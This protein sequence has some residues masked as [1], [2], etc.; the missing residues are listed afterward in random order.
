VPIPNSVP[1]KWV[2]RGL[3]DASDG[4]NS[5]PGAQ[6]QLINLIPDPS[7]AGIYVPRP[8]AQIET[9]FTGVNAPTGPGDV[10]AMLTVGDLE[11]GMIASTRFA[12]KDEPYCYDL[13]NG[14][15]LPVAGVTNANT[16]TTQPSSGDWVPPIMAQVS[17]RVIV[18][19]PGFPGGAIKF[20][21]FDVS[22][23]SE[24][25]LGNTHTSTLIDGNPSVLGVQVGMSITGA[26]IPAN[27][28][29][30]ATTEFVLTTTALLNLNTLTHFGS[31]LGIA[32][33]Q[34]VA[35]LD[36]PFGTTVSSITTAAGVWTGST[37]SNTTVDNLVYASG[38][39]DFPI[40]GDPIS[41][42][43]IPANTEV[44]A[45]VAISFQVLASLNG[46]T[47]IQV[48]SIDGIV[49]NQNV[50]G[51]GIPAATTV[52]SATLFTLNTT[53]DITSGSAVIINL[54]STA[55]LLAGQKVIGFGIP[56]ISTGIFAQ[57]TIIVSVDSPTQVTISTP[58]DHTI[59]ANAITFSGGSV[60]LNNAAT[61]TVNFNLL[62]FS[63]LGV[64]LSQPAGATANGVSITVNTLTANL[65]AVSLNAAPINVPVTFT[66]ATITLSQAATGSVANTSLTIA[67]GTRAAPLWGAGDCDRNP[68]LSTP[69]GVM[70]MNGRAYFADGL[71][72][73]P[74]SDSGLP[75]RRSNQPDVQALTTNDGTAVTIVAPLEL[76]AP[77]TGGI[78]QAAIAFSGDG[79]MRQITGD[80][81]TADLKMNLLPIATG[82][83]APLSVIPCSLGT[84]F[85]SPQGLRF[86]RPD[87]SVTDPVGVDGQGVTHPF[88]YAVFPSRI[89]AEANVAVLRITVQHGSEPGQPFQEFWFD[90]SR[91]TWSGPHSFPARLIQ[92]W[93][94]S[95][96]MA[97][98]GVTASLWKSD[99][100]GP[101]YG[102]GTAADFIEN[103]VQL[104]WTQETV[105]LPDNEHMAM[106]SMVEANLM[107]S[108]APGDIIQVVA[109]DEQGS[110]L[111]A[112]NVVP[113]V[114]N[115]I[116]R[117]RSLHWH[118]PIIFKQMSMQARG[119]SNSRVRIGNLYMR[120]EILGYNND[121]DAVAT[122]YLRVVPLTGDTL[123]AV[124]GLLA[125]RIDPLG[126]LAT[127]A[128]VM[129]P[130]PSNGDSFC[131]S[132][133]QRLAVVT[134][135][136]PAST[137][138]AGTSGGPFTLEANGG[139]CWQYDMAL[140]QWL[141]EL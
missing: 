65:S 125:F 130:T 67:G 79:A 32:V 39:A 111:D 112:V 55:G 56:P 133:T 116:L 99:T 24:V 127:L 71:D 17:P 131:I 124:A 119:T 120:Y 138:M 73:I 134:V 80:M 42:G 117:E 114:T 92:H 90:L 21:W 83:L 63:S 29:V 51:F 12:G 85:V 136:A 16:P 62:T 59:V 36:I 43:S 113:T 69:L 5:F 84:A 129:P 87:G 44:A 128:V 75:C 140:N 137:T 78:V 108:A 2:P 60:V 91:K 40:I 25:V 135:S 98:I 9:S 18:T 13:A 68:L 37:H 4:T 102:A 58:A 123:T 122:P 34:D 46:T 10:Q 6:Q 61:T 89:C 8:A 101:S 76:S 11:Y 121:E 82:S 30:A 132:T 54:A 38:N 31:S 97:P 118:E 139:T 14:V 33:G 105:L 52:V 47:T 35:G 50:T 57:T 110:A 106:N 81:A 28:N 95:F 48:D 74:F 49:A 22:G 66:G 3:T 27:T 20:G 15:F 96:I 109:I 26:N 103:G 1:T 100:V 45:V 141:P 93:R 53:G 23:F 107:C 7:T 88:Q 94:A 41:G 77:I 19:H 72:G 70:Q 64:T 104:S 126:E 86:V 115:S